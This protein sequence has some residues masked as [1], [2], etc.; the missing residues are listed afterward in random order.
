MFELTGVDEDTAK[1]IARLI[2]FRLP[3]EVRLISRV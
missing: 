3:F 1:H 2:R